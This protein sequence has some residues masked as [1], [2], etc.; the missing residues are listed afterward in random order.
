MNSTHVYQSNHLSNQ[1]SPYLLQHV[2]NPVDWYPWG[3]KAFQKANS[4]GKM[5]FLSIGYSTCHWCHVMAHESFESNEVADLLS[6][7]YVSIKVDREERPDIDEVYMNVCQSL[8]GSGG[9]PLTV[10][11][12]PDKKP[13]FAGTYFPTHTYGGRIGFIELLNQ[14]SHLWHNDRDSLIEQSNALVEHFKSYNS[15]EQQNKSNEQ[16]IELTYNALLKQYDSKYGGFSSRPKFPSPHNLFFLLRYYKKTNEL[17][18]LKMVETT[19][20]SMYAGGIFDHVGYGFSRYSTDSKW[21]VPH[22]EKMLYDNALLILAYTESY[23]ITKNELYRNIVN[24]TIEYITRDMTS[25]DGAFYSALDADSEGIEG[26]YYVFDYA[27]LENL[28]E[29][30]ELK[31]LEKHY[32]VT[33]SGNFE[34][35]NILNKTKLENNKT[36]YDKQVIDKLYDYRKKR[37]PPFLDTKILSSWNG[38]MIAA[39]SYA[40]KVLNDDYIQYAIKS[41]DFIISNMIDDKSNLFTS[42]KDNN[43]SNTGFLPD[44]ANISWGFI[45]LYSATLDFKYLEYAIELSKSM[46]DKFWNNNLHTFFMDEDSKGEL[47]FRPKDDYDGAIPSGNSVA[48]MN[49]IRLF[50]YTYNESFKNIID[51]CVESFVPTVEKYPSAYMH[52]VSAL[53]LYDQSHRQIVITGENQEELYNKITKQFIPATTVILYDGNEKL[54]KIMPEL[55]NYHVE[56]NLKAYVCEDFTCGN[57]I[58]SE[59]KLSD[60]LAII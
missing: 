47:P 17:Y 22:F 35:K 36:E 42:Y 59:E 21:L 26:K 27:E 13:F 39:L 15:A 60:K 51:E 16:I 28:L 43:V 56:D 19:L 7:D 31:Y 6:R 4:E 3:D 52:F 58:D 9:W 45:E 5:I 29:K 49:L 32:N 33:K 37:I 14:I 24:K 46:I 25:P 38:L 18:A 48:I 34:G 1:T 8:T 53:L 55:K 54:T 11:M 50:N 23:S 10:I 2:N 44:Y 40:G 20:Q 41:A 30:D 57:P 12:T